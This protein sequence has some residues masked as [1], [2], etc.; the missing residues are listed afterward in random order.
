MISDNHR[1]QKF[2]PDGQF[3][4]KW[5]TF[6]SGDGQ[7]N[8]MGGISIDANGNVYVTDG[9]DNHRIQKFTADGQYLRTMGDVYV[10]DYR[11]N[12]IQVFSENLEMTSDR[13]IIVAAGG[14]HRANWLWSSIRASAKSA[15]NTLLHQGFTKHSIYYLSED[16]DVDFDQNGIADDVDADATNKNLQQAITS[17]AAGAE[18]VTIYMVDHG[19]PEKFWM[20][21]Q[22]QSLQASK[23]GEWLDTLQST[24][25]G[26]ITFIYEACQSGSFI[27]HLQGSGE[28][29]LI[30]ST[31][32]EEDAIFANEGKNSF[33]YYFWNNIFDGTDIKTAFDSAS[34]EHGKLNPVQ[35]PQFHDNAVGTLAQATQVGK[36]RISQGVGPN[37]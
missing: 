24:I 5:G 21:Y 30:T 12:R 34:T 10:T 33:S 2:T 7:F 17:W 29:I 8:S 37:I 36:G 11:N 26:K 32:A 1:I 9:Y 13:A 23:L 18:D 19:E 16:I 6:G 31:S 35:N 15:Y 25:T 20:K 27:P 3:L 22:S 4:S 14:S 28:R